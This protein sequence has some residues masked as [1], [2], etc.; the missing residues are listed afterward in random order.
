M[1]ERI[2]ESFNSFSDYYQKT[3]LRRLIVGS[4]VG[5]LLW[6]SIFLFSNILYFFQNND[7]WLGT[8]LHDLPLV[9]A[10]LA[11]LVSLQIWGLL[12]QPTNDN[13]ENKSKINA[14]KS[15]DEIRL[16]VTKIKESNNQ[17]TEF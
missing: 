15:A 13:Q 8:F 1:T 9:G 3:L 16:N 12:P 2:A 6:F 5:S 14:E 17:N 7:I 11:L 4:I 10:I